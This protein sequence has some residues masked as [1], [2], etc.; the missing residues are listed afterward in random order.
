[1]TNNRFQLDQHHG[2]CVRIPSSP[3]YGQVCRVG[4][5]QVITFNDVLRSED[6]DPGIVRLARHQ[7]HRDRDRSI[8]AVWKSAGGQDLLEQYQAVQK[9]Q[10][11]SVGEFVASFVVTPPPASDTLFIGLYEVRG[12]GTCPAGQRDRLTGEDV[13]G[14]ICYELRPD[15]RL[16][17]YRERLVV[18]WG[19]ATRAYVQLASRQPKRLLALRDQAEPPFPGFSQFCVD[20]RDIT[21]LYPSWQQRLR[22]VKGI[23]VLV[24][25]D[26]GAQYVGSAKGEDSL[27]GRFSDYA[28]TGDGGNVELRRRAGARYQVGILQIVDQSLPDHSI[29]EIEG[30][31]KR[32]LMTREYGL[33]LN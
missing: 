25:K 2:K 20:I 21:G 13:S 14:F 11:F 30:W 9:R 8:Y 4:G 15:H 1:M 16:D 33:N 12:M 7:D 24:D 32:K 3:N 17:E 19:K 26:S 5:A 29:E 31:W 18:D 28:R 22:E 6:L 23:Y 27:Y 10:F